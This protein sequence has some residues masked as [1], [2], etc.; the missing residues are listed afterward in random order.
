MIDVYQYFDY[1]KLLKDLYQERKSR[2]GKFSYRFICLKTG[3]RSA[4]YFSNVLAGKS[5]ISLKVVLK[6]A[7]LFAMKRGESDYFELLVLFNQAK[8]HD[9]KNLL[10]DRILKV[11]KSKVKTLD[12]SY[13][14]LFSH[15]YYVALREVMDYY[16][17]KGDFRELG[18]QVSPAVTAK[19]AERAVAV[20]ET[21]GLIAK[22]PKGVYERVEALISTGEETKSMA[23]VQ[24]QKTTLD[25]AKRAFDAFPLEARD[26][27][28]L[29]ISVSR[30]N[31]PRI[32]EKIRAVRREI[33]ELAK[34]DDDTDTVFHLNILAFPLSKWESKPQDG[35]R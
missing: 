25:L 4:G 35:D 31:F 32:K 1:R 20:L 27:S 13:Y 3:I 26:I 10:F 5:N 15:W 14:E 2:D 12:A 6:L 29:T 23:I 9:E 11:K 19:E 28:T 24:F 18:Q 22:N 21:L 16:P 17:F 7:Q 34:A 30:R 33:L 8:T